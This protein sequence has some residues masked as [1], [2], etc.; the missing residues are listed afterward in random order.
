MHKGVPRLETRHYI[1]LYQENDEN[2]KYHWSDSVRKLAKLD[3]ESVQALHRQE[4]KFSVWHYG[5]RRHNARHEKSIV[6][7]PEASA[8][9]VPIVL[10]HFIRRLIHHFC[11]LLGCSNPEL[12]GGYFA[13]TSA[14]KNP[15]S[16]ALFKAGPSIGPF[17]GPFKS[18]FISAHIEA[19][20][21]VILVAT[22]SIDPGALD[23]AFG[24]HARVCHRTRCAYGA[25]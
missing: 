2:Y 8:L 3:F 4:G 10:V 23:R 15:L 1:S 16:N 14:K 7:G 6:L 25:H 22:S 17:Q 20:F 5:R 24:D 13:N 18:P 9:C 19:G 12:L 11:P 21:G